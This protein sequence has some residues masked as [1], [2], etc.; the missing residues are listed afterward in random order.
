MY[1]DKYY[2]VEVDSIKNIMMELNHHHIDLL[3]LDI[4]GSEIKVLEQ[5][6]NDNIFPKYLCIESNY[7]KDDR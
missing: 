7:I 2:M 3:K 5:M 4:E 1:S 6:I